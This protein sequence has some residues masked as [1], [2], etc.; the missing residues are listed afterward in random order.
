MDANPRSERGARPPSAIPHPQR[1]AILRPL[2]PSAF[3]F[4][5][6]PQSSLL[7]Q[8]IGEPGHFAVAVKVHN[9]QRSH[10]LLL[11]WKNSQRCYPLRPTATLLRE[12]P[13]MGQ[14][15]SGRNPKADQSRCE[16]PILNRETRQIRERSFF[17][18][19]SGDSCISRFNRLRSVLP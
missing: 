11:W 4:Q 19:C 8:A 1:D 17:Q 2:Q 15:G 7:A 12:W 14:E 9:S 10:L 18:F 6:C 5:P 3:S 13:N 16:A